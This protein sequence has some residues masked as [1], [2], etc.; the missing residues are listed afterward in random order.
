[1]EAKIGSAVKGERAMRIGLFR[2]EI[3]AAEPYRRG[4]LESVEGFLTALREKAEE[5]RQRFMTPE[6]LLEDREGYR[7]KY[8]RMLGYPLTDYE[9][10]KREPVRCLEQTPAGVIPCEEGEVAV[11]RMRLSVLGDY[12]MYGLLFLPARIREDAPF[13]I[14]QHGGAGTPELCSDFYGDTN[15]NHQTRR[16]LERGAVV[17]APQLLLWSVPAYGDPYDRQALDADLKQLGSSITAL[18]VFGIMRCL[19]YFANQ[20]YC[21]TEHIGMAGLSYGGF[22]TMMTAAADTR[23]RSAY[24]SCSFVD[25]V[26]LPGFPDWKWQGSGLTFNEAGIAALIA[27]RAVCFDAGDRDDLFGSDMSR[28]EY[29]AAKPFF[30]AQGVPDN[31]FLKCFDGTHEMD[32]ADDCMDFF[33]AHL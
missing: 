1:M 21:H 31:I 18:E 24:A 27:P 19:D 26:G 16:L 4:Y 2:E 28:R 20:P 8:R 30:E 23:I 9:T 5:E 6:A 29:A 32:P 12:T 33:F 22:Y 7:E 11:S 25:A 10:L 17:F 14:S 13:V 15:Y 3:S